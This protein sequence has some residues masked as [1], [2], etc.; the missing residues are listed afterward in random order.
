MRH[1]CPALFAF[2][3][4][5]HYASQAGILS[6]LSVWITGS[7]RV[8]KLDPDSLGKHSQSLFSETFDSPVFEV[9]SGTS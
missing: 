7:T 3:T 1:H 5:W 4:W 9:S 8:N 6:F 2:E